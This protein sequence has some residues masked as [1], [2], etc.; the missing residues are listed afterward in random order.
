MYPVA[1]V[2]MIFI[3]DYSYPLESEVPFTDWPR[4]LKFLYSEDFPM[5]VLFKP[6]SYHETDKTDCHT[7]NRPPG[8][9]HNSDKQRPVFYSCK[10]S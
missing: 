4:P 7:Q 8:H 6:P 3:S 1:P 10:I 9:I 5:R 2:T